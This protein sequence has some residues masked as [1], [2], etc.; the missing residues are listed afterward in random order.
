MRI[1]TLKE[2]D[3]LVNKNKEFTLLSE[4]VDLEGIRMSIQ[5]FLVIT[6]EDYIVLD[7]GNGWKND[8]KLVV[9]QLL[10]QENIDR[11]EITKVLLSHVHKDHVDGLFLNTN[12][13]ELTFP[14]AEIYIQKREF[15]YALT[16]IGNPSFDLETL[17]RL[18]NLPNIHW[19]E[20]DKGF[21]AP[22]ISYEV[23]GGHTP[24]HQVFWIKENGETIFMAPIISRSIR[25]LNFT[26][27][28]KVISTEKKQKNCD[29]SGRNKPKK[30]IGAFSCIT[31]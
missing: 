6:D 30:K 13:S 3:F 21:I 31:I 19:M 12:S 27:P 18:E 8:R 7:G 9:E 28:T 4:A 11:T 14:N 17:K 22:S 1:I 10:D 5:S 2:G 20:E 15:D 23:T 24:F 26:L 25:I 29:K 16:Q